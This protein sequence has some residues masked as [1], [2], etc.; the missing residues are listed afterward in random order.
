MVGDLGMITM[1][2][3]K[4]RG[5]EKKCSAKAKAGQQNYLRKEAAPS[6]G[7]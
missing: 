4:I 5:R 1:I 3:V 2:T 7:Q 6:D